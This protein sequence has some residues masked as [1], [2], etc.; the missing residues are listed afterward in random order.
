MTS[1]KRQRH[2]GLNGLGQAFRLIA[3]HRATRKQARRG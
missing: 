2:P 3:Y 1:A